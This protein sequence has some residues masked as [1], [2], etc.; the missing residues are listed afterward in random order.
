MRHI[1]CAVFVLLLFVGSVWAERNEKLS[2][3]NHAIV[4]ARLQ[5]IEAEI[6]QLKDHPWAGQYFFGFRDGRNATLTLAPENGFTMIG[7][8]RWE[9]DFLD[10][11]TVDWDGKHIRLNCTFDVKSGTIDGEPIKRK[12]I[13]WGERV[14]LIPT[15]RII[16]F[17]NA[18]NSGWEPRNCTHGRFYLRRGDEEKEVSGKPELPKEFMPYLLDKPIGA[19]IVSVKDIRER[20]RFWNIATFVVDKGQNDGLL[21]GMEL[22]VV[23]PFVVGR[24]TL[25]KVEETQSEAEFVYPR[26]TEIES[27]FRLFRTSAPAIGWQLSTCPNRNR[28]RDE[29]EKK[30]APEQERRGFSIW[31]LLQRQT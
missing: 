15:F 31:N 6:A 5:K 30:D 23:R 1:F 13:R 4:E 9:L 10:H 2:E 12:P 8:D 25:T 24:V 7:Y 14:Y 27:L 26:P 18:I 21:P 17:C 3:E 28:D 19:T 11:G 16:D 22:H 29:P 20:D